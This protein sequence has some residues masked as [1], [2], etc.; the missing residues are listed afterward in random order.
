MQNLERPHPFRAAAAAANPALRSFADLRHSLHLCF[1]V[2]AWEVAR[3]G[4]GALQQRAHLRGVVSHHAHH[5][6][7][8]R[9]AARFRIR[10]LGDLPHRKRQQQPRG[11]NPLD[12]AGADLP[13]RG[14]P[15]MVRVRAQVLNADRSPFR[16]IRSPRTH[17]HPF[18][19]PIDSA[20]RAIA[21]RRAV[22]VACVAVAAA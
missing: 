17:R 10:L 1:P 7:F 15:P 21:A 20:P 8:A 12:P 11:E 9:H 19:F 4:R 3:P 2:A 18:Q 6:V 13:V 22:G 14:R 5:R 16:T